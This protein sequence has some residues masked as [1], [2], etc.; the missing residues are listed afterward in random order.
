M[1]ATKVSTFVT[2]TLNEN[3]SLRRIIQPMTILW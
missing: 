2:N 3:I 1:F